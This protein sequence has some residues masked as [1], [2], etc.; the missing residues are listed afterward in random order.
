MENKYKQQA[1]IKDFVQR[2]VVASGAVGSNEVFSD[3]MPKSVSELDKFVLILTNS[4]Q[5][6]DSHAQGSVNIYLYL[7]PHTDTLRKENQALDKMENSIRNAVN[8]S[9][10]EHYSVAVQWADSN[11]D[12]QSDLL[13][14]VI[15]VSLTVK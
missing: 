2:L 12:N 1:R 6:Y 3:K 7:K 11:Y 4:S 5:D 9:R 14:H 15:N 8:A 10:D 13:Y